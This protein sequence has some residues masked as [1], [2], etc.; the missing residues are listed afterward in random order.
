MR[1]NNKKGTAER[2][3]R[4]RSRFNDSLGGSTVLLWEEERERERGIKGTGTEST[5]FKLKRKRRK[6]SVVVLALGVSRESWW[7][8][9][10][11]LMTV[12]QDSSLRKPFFPPFL[13]LSLFLS[14]ASPS[15]P[16]GSSASLLEEHR[17]WCGNS[18]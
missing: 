4:N 7:T 17:G 10:S 9:S 6:A 16:H 18:T 14:Q 12:T 8:E 3:A 15:A 2:C 5:Q 13:S 1:K 11:F